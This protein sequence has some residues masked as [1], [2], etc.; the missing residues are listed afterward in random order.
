MNKVL[1]TFWLPDKVKEDFASEFELICPEKETPNFSPEEQLKLLPPCAGALVGMIPTGR[2]FFEAGQNLKVVGTHSVGFDHIDI[3]CAKEKGVRIVNTPREVCGPTAELT[4]AL[5]LAAMRGVVYFDR[6]VR[7]RRNTAL[8]LFTSDT[9][10]FSSTP[11]GKKLGIVGFGRIGRD[12]A[13]KAKAFDMEIYYYDPIRADAATE[14]ALDVKYL[15]F[16]TLL[17]TADVVS[18]HCPF[19]EENR[20]LIAEEEFMRM[21]PDAYLVNTARGPLVEERALVRALALGKIKGAA[22]DVYEFEP[23]VGELLTALENVVLVPH[24]GTYTYEVR[25][26]MAYE[27]L[28]GIAACLKGETPEN[29]VV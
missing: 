9:L 6:L 10:A 22:L 4:M 1:S 11:C 15:P 18:L 19:T 27:A 24:I 3:A 13:R 23:K 7:E 14:A 16:E 29:I 28:N 2:A 20:H 12:V 8:G 5:M 25:L 17:E 26:K 21:K